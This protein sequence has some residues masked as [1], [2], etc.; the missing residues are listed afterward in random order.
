ME[1]GVDCIAL[2]AGEHRDVRNATTGVTEID[3][4]QKDTA[5]RRCLDSRV[6]LSVAAPRASPR[7]TNESYLFGLGGFLL[8]GPGGC[9]R[10]AT[11]ISPPNN[12]PMSRTAMMA[13]FTPGAT[14]IGPAT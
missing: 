4:I 13:F 7:A 14:K 1:R 8:G 6:R 5:G 10:L 11:M 3:Q 12:T 9:T 2:Q